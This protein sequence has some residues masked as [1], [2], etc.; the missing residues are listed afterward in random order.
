MKRDVDME[1][2]Y[3]LDDLN[4]L[5]DKNMLGKMKAKTCMPTW[6]V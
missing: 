1:N 4:R 2:T 6:T 3:K 5:V